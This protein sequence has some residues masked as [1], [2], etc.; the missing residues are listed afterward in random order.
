MK[1]NVKYWQNE[2][3][4]LVQ[5]PPEHISNDIFLV[6]IKAILVKFQNTL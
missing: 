6:G 3:I 4:S 5:L 1:L 2:F